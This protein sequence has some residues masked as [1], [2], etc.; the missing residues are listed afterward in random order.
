MGFQRLMNC[1]YN[2]QS[3]NICPYCFP[4]NMTGTTPH[5]RYNVKMSACTSG[6][7]SLS[8]N[9]IVIQTK[10]EGRCTHSV[11]LDKISYQLLSKS[12]L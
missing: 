10:E 1:L 3:A 2:D 11:C 8:P 9:G 4:G 12:C 5:T 7:C 6:G